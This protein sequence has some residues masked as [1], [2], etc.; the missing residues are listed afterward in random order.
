MNLGFWIAWFQ[1]QKLRI[2]P[3]EYLVLKAGIPGREKDFCP[4][5]RDWFEGFFVD[6]GLNR[7]VL[8][9]RIEL[10]K[11]IESWRG[12]LDHNKWQDF[13]H[14]NKENRTTLQLHPPSDFFP[15]FL[16]CF[17]FSSRLIFGAE[18]H[19]FVASF[20]RKQ[21]ALWKERKEP[22]HPLTRKEITAD[23]KIRIKHYGFLFLLTREYT[24]ELM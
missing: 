10:K 17:P 12:G 3:F 2:F 6:Q 21:L 1:Y 19:V 15:L 13:Y 20:Q 23:H 14:T 11:D 24:L 16:C 22:H 8:N 5:S 4:S 7:N 18:D 9:W